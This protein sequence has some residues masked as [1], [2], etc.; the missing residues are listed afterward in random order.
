MNPKGQHVLHDLSGRLDMR[1]ARLFSPRSVA[2]NVAL[3]LNGDGK[4]LVPHNFPIRRRR[5]VEE[6]RSDS[7]ASLVEYRDSQVTNC[8][9]N[10]ELADTI[11]G[12]QVAS[13]SSASDGQPLHLA[14]EGANDIVSKNRPSRGPASLFD[15]SSERLRFRIR[16]PR[17]S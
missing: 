13:A 1:H 16:W 9:I 4:I 3:F 17:R 2:R 11:D 10:G 6:K 7:E 15:R 8:R 12:K 14:P 5:L